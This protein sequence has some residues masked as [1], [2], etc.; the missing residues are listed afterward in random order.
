MPGP[1]PPVLR[2]CLPPSLLLV[3]IFFFCL[4]NFPA[5]SQNASFLL[6]SICLPPRAAVSPYRNS[7]LSLLTV[8]SVNRPHLPVN[9]HGS[10]PYPHPQHPG[11]ELRNLH[12]QLITRVFL[13]YIPSSLE[14]TIQKPIG[15]LSAPMTLMAPQSLACPSV[16]SMSP[17]CLQ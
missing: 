6:S 10:R 17:L 13:C 16:H 12:L 14:P 3:Q 9:M 5:S 2:G 4:R 8:R 7:Q 11:A 1:V 15:V